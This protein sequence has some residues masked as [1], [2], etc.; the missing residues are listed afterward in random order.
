MFKLFGLKI[1]AGLWQ[2][3]KPSPLS[4]L[5]TRELID[6]I[7]G[8]SPNIVMGA[9]IEAIDELLA[10]CRKDRNNVELYCGGT[11][12]LFELRS[13]ATNDPLRRAA[14]GAYMD[15]LNM[16]PQLTYRPSSF[17]L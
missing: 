13:V 12:A 17:K 11:R 2:A 3:K 6:R 15:I 4:H 9:R 8:S 1:T 14:E 10:R 5:G 7:S 16:R